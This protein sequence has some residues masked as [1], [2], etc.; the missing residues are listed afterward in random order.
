MSLSTIRFLKPVW[1][2]K[3]SNDA[4]TLAGILIAAVVAILTGFAWVIAQIN[5]IRKEI[6]DAFDKQ[7]MYRHEN[8]NR[9]TGVIAE[10]EDRLTRRVERVENGR[11]SRHTSRE[12]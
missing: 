3:L 7:N 12:R 10:V 2:L 6:A 11:D 9:I 8:T 1:P 5:G 4:S